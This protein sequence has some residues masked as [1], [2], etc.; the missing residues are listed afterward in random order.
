MNFMDRGTGDA[1]CGLLRL[2]A[3]VV[4][5]DTAWYSFVQVGSDIFAR[6]F[7]S[8]LAPGRGLPVPPDFK[9]KP[10]PA[11]SLFS[12]FDLAASSAYTGHP[13]A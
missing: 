7:Q 11:I 6:W 9:I 12:L 5:G 3:G 2:A 4:Q 8:L 1:S 13:L 10:R